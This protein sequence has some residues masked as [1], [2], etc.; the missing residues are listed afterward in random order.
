MIAYVAFRRPEELDAHVVVYTTPW[1]GYCRAAKRLLQARGIDFVE[2]DVR[3]DGEARTWLQHASGQH[4]VPQIFI[5]GRSV[6]GY[7][8][9][10]AL[11]DEGELVASAKPPA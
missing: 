2:I 1:C 9:L 7:T 6:G 5:G 4:T 10:A 11:D 3:G 8:E